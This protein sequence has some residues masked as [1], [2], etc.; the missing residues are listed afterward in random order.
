M[1]L[2]QLV[3]GIAGHHRRAA[4]LGMERH[5]LEVR[6]RREDEQQAR[7]QEHE[8]RQAERVGRHHPEREV[9]RGADRAVGGGEEPRRA[10]AALDRDEGVPAG[11]GAGAGGRRGGSVGGRRAAV[12]RGVHPRQVIPASSRFLLTLERLGRGRVDDHAAGALA[13]H[14]LERAVEHLAGR[15]PARHR[16]HDHVRSGFQRLAHDPVAG[17]TRPHLGRPAPH[18]LAAGRPTGGRPRSPPGRSPRPRGRGASRPRC[19]GTVRVTMTR[20]SPSLVRARASAPSPSRLRV[21]AL[22]ERDQRRP[23]TRPARRRPSAASRS[24]GLGQREALAPP[25]ERRS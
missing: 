21:R 10:D 12:R 13:E 22:L 14:H 1:K 3:E 23:G 5:A 16:H 18:A 9:D 19:C 4:T 17:F 2:E 11:A 20:T 7:D 25:V 24:R 15:P 6:Q 8:R